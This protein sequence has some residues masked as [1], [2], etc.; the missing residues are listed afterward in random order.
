M[1]K[2]DKDKDGVTAEAGQDANRRVAPRIPA[3]QLPGLGLKLWSGG[4]VKLLNL[5]QTGVRF[6][7]DR[8][9]VPAARVALQLIT[10]D[11]PEPVTVHGRVIRV[12][13]TRVERGSICYEV[14]M[15]F[16]RPV[17]SLKLPIREEPVSAGPIASP[18][19]AAVPPALAALSAAAPVAA[20]SPTPAAEALIAPAEPSDDDVAALASALLAA[21]ISAPDPAPASAPDDG[22]DDLGELLLTAHVTQSRNEVWQVINGNEW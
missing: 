9:L 7:C 2:V 10:T 14:A 20:A 3:Q 1:D 8:R 16:D 21:P 12:R 19:P 4:S 17:D 6:E 11:S 18:M 5:S 13:L 22:H 15:A